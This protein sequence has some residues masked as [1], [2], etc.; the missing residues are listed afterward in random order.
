VS[1]AA[2]RGGRPAVPR[3]WLP[4]PLLS[5]ALLAAWALAYNGVTPGVLLSGA[6]VAFAVPLAGARFWPEYPRGARAAPALRLSGVLLWDV[7]V[8]NVRVAALVLGPRARLR[9][10]FFLVPLDVESPT[11]VAL[12]AAAISL[13]PGTVS[14]DY[15]PRAHAL[16]VHALDAAD[17]EAEVARIKARYERPLREAFG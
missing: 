11:A 2:P 15:D 8:A 9:P 6:V 4:Q 17:P 13:T 10:A 3:R 12:L 16:L 7:L 5:A 14:A 1:A